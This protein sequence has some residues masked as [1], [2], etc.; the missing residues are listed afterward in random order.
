MRGWP[1]IKLLPTTTNFKFVKYAR[2]AAVFSVVLCV[3]SII[4]SR[5]SV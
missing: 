5:A 4:V 2:L 1:L 3:A